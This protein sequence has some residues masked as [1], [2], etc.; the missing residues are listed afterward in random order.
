MSADTPSFPWFAV[1]VRSNCEAMSSQMLLTKG[2][3]T[4][5]PLYRSRR[6]WSDR[7]REIDAPLF[8]GYTFCQ[9]DPHHKM[10]ILSTP[11]VVDILQSSTGPAPVEESEIAAVRAMLQSGLP[12]GPHPFLQVGQRVLV[13]RGPLA[14]Q[15]GIIVCVKNKYRLVVSLS[16][17]QRS[18]SAE[19]DRLCVRPLNPPKPRAVA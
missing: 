3:N 16:L 13:E 6:Q 18:V 19:I 12:V 5:L 2:Y 15:E 11:G 17:L 10:P 1:R 8:P 4:Y 14:G 7:I 9:F